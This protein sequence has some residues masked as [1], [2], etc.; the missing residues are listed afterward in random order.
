M[1]ELILLALHA[2]AT[3]INVHSVR[4]HVTRAQAAGATDAD[5][6]DVLMSIIGVANHSLYFAVPVLL[7]E[8]KRA[9]RHDEAA[10][11]GSSPEM[12]AIKADFLRTRGFWNEQ[13]DD[14]ARL[15][16][17][18]FAALSDVSM[19][20]WKSGS[21]SPKDREFIYIAID[22]SVTHMYAPGLALHIRNAL[23]WG[24]NREEILEI[25]QLTS[26][27]G[28]EGYIL[29]AESL[30]GEPGEETKPCDGE[31]ERSPT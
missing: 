5:I 17:G 16:P 28:M 10:M 14:L 24:A 4:R 12:E 25:F 20:P 9:G 13:R 1:K 29:G 7:T 8:L 2:S 11:P 3:S 23:Q 21:L 18:Y 30:F 31:N 15:M 6:L 27:M 26:L 22:C 19:E